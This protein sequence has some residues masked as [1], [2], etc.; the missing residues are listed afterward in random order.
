MKPQMAAFREKEEMAE[1][2]EEFRSARMG[3][4]KSQVQK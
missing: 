4:Q 2:R 1:D 3:P